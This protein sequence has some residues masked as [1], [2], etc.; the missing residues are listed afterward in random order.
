MPTA[1]APLTFA[2][3]PTI[4]PTAPAAP[5]TSTVSPSFRAPTSSS[6]KYAVMPGMPSAP[7]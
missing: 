7:R 3:C 5:E 4:D 2:I 1:R 6:P